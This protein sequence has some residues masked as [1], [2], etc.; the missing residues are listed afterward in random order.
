MED[1]KELFDKFISLFEDK[2]KPSLEILKE[3]AAIPNLIPALS[4]I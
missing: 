3:L 1:S 2:Y 4:K